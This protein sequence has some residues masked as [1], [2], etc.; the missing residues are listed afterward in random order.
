MKVK[1]K[2]LFYSFLLLF[3]AIIWGL[4]FIV[5]KNSLDYMTFLYLLAFRFSIGALGM[6]FI[7]HKK[8]RKIRIENIKSG[9][10]L[11]G[12]LFIAF[13]LQ[14]KAL[15][16]TTVG[17]NAFLT[18][19][20]V[21]LVPLLDWAIKK[22]RP[23]ISSFMATIPCITGIGLLS[24]DS[25]LSMNLGDL[26][27]LMCAIFYALHMVVSDIYMKK[28]QD[29]VILNIM[30]IISAGI[31]SWI[32]AVIFEPFPIMGFQASSIQGILYLG[33]GC[34]M[35]AF[36]FQ[37]IGQSHTSPSTSSLLL[38]T[39]SLFGVLFSVILL[40]E[41]INGRM[42]LGFGLIFLAIII[43]DIGIDFKKL[44]FI[45]LGNAKDFESNET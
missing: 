4:G 3:T 39:E 1:N 37:M 8:L 10:L 19:A 30:Q 45:R 22:I 12:F 18:A 23:G 9:L 34:T 26:L 13:T 20:Y 5:V 44:R 11:G 6:C 15:E 41:T 16:Y 17:K 14:I 38:S 31:F 28:G 29:P 32:F 35:L 43:S 42:I 25:S 21:V 24:L 40:G 27:T 33:I 36:L 2:N 7:F